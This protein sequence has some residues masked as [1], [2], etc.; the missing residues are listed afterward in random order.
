LADSCCALSANYSTSHFTAIISHTFMKKCLQLLYIYIYT[1]TC[2]MQRHNCST[3]HFAAIIS[4]IVDHFVQHF[5]QHHG[6]HGPCVYFFSLVTGK[7][8]FFCIH[9]VHS[10]QHHGLSLQA[11]FLWR[12]FSVWSLVCICFYVYKRFIVCS[13][14]ALYTLSP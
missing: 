4:H 8:L 3:S 7:Y 12:I 10:M 9:E 1:H 14:M 13:T 5:V 6:M 11:W 2:D